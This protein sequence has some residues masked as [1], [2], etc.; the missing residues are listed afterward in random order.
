MY[1]LSPILSTLYI[2]IYIYIYVCM[3]VCVCVCVCVCARARLNTLEALIMMIRKAAMNKISLH[4][5]KRFCNILD[6]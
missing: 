2:Y 6:K 4:L 3:C 5:V 1:A